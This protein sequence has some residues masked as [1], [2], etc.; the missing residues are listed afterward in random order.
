MKRTIIITGIVVVLSSLALFLFLKITTDKKEQAH[1]LTKVMRGT[2]EI[3]VEE[4]G[5]LTAEQA[6]EIRG[7]DIVRNRSFRAAGIRITDLV[8]EGTI[9]QKGDYIASLDRTTFDNN[10]KDE[11]NNLNRL[12]EEFDMKILDTAVTLSTLRDDIRNQVFAN[13]E[14]QIVLEQ[15]IYEPPAVQRQAGLEVDRMN[16]FLEQKQRIYLLRLSQASSDLRILKLNLDMQ[17]RKVNDLREVLAGFTVTAPDDGMVIYK[18]DRT[19]VKIRT[20]SM[21]HPFDPVIATLPDLS[22]LLSRIYISEIEINRIRPGQEVQIRTD[23]YREKVYKGTVAGIANIGEQIP[24]SDS[25][26]FEV[27]IKIGEIDP[28]LRPSMTTDNKIIVRTYNDVI[29]IPSASVHAGPDNIPFVYTR[30]GTRQ[31][32][33][34]GEANDDYVI[35]EKG[36]D[37]DASIYLSTPSRAERFSLAGQELIPEILERQRVKEMDLLPEIPDDNLLADDYITPV[38][39]VG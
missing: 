19:G 32:V 33:L 35:V 34:L 7:P 26:V 27:L 29:Y 15:S 25:K 23:A 38:T 20:G 28:L 6:L 37:E 24:N 30:G 9:V 12:Q 22:S 13:S 1:S 11:I 39:D 17:R 14:A 3:A 8:P 18:K 10:L 31:V 36:L 16:R 4:T 5:E 21:M 2:F